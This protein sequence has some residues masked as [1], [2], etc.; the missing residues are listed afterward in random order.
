MMDGPHIRPGGQHQ[1]LVQ[2]YKNLLSSMNCHV[3]AGVHAMPTKQGGFCFMR[4][5]KESSSSGHGRF[6]AC[7]FFRSFVFLNFAF[8]VRWMHSNSQLV[9]LIVI[10]NIYGTRRTPPKVEALNIQN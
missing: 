10:K 9:D 5:W 6:V 1:V 7:L 4:K 8:Q 2:P 3:L